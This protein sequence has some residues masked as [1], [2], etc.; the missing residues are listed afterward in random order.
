M[1]TALRDDHKIRDA[2]VGVMEDGRIREN[3]KKGDG[4]SVGNRAPINKNWRPARVVRDSSNCP[5]RAY[6]SD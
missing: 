5:M 3:V 2:E 6:Q 1:V 4:R